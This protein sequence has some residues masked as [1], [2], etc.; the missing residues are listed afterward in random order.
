[1]AAMM[2][3]MKSGIV[4]TVWLRASQKTVDHHLAALAT[5]A[6]AADDQ[7]Q[8]VR[9]SGRIDRR[10]IFTHPF[11]GCHVGQPATSVSQ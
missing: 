2:M 4:R 3:Y 9:R 1:M 10:R 7:R 11:G 5:A 6:E 8:R